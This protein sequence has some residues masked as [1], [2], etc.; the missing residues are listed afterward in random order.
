[1]TFQISLSGKVHIQGRVVYDIFMMLGEVGGLRDFIVLTSSSL[2]AVFSERF[3]L[4]DLVQRLYRS[5]NTNTDRH[6]F[7]YQH[8]SSCFL[9]FSSIGLGWCH[10]NNKHAKLKD[11]MNS[12]K[13]ELDVVRLLRLERSLSTLLHLLYPRVT[14]RLL[15]L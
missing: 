8:F 9:V 3:L 13:Y 7:E 12:I 5:R 11:G 2:M 6:K 1:M 14:R 15:M 4:A 10:S